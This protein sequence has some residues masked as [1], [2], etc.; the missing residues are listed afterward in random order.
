[1]VAESSEFPF[2]LL[3][4]HS[5]ALGIHLLHDQNE[6]RNG[7]WMTKGVNFTSN[8][9]RFK[10]RNSHPK[11]EQ[12]RECFREIERSGTFNKKKRDDVKT[13]HYK[14]GMAGGES[15]DLRVERVS[16]LLR[17]FIA[18]VVA[19]CVGMVL[20]LISS[21]GTGHTIIFITTLLAA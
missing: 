16:L 19:M 13:N 21:A 11:V 12:F 20:E 7:R 2:L 17:S 9:S 1:M 8:S 10:E 6:G 18:T 5:N 15:Y 4:Y 3:H 14:E